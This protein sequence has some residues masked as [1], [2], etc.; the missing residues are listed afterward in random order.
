[1]RTNQKQ[2]GSFVLGYAFT[3]LD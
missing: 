2:F 3:L 1:M